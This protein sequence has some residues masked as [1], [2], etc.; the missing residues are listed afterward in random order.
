MASIVV[1]MKSPGEWAS[2][3]GVIATFA[4]GTLASHATAA[5]AQSPAAAPAPDSIARLGR[6]LFFDPA[7]SASGKLACAT[8]HDPKYAYGPPP[9][10]AIALGG[11]DMNQP[12]TRAV[13]SLRYLQGN[14]QF[15]EDLHFADGDVGPGGGLTWD[16]RAASLH[17]QAAI[18]LLAANEM[19]NAG[20]ADVVRKLARA[21]YAPLFRS[22][23]GERIFADPEAAFAAA[24][25]ALEA[26]QQVDG[27]FFPYTSRYDAFLR[28]EIELT[29]QEERGVAL[30]KDPR[31]G[32]CASCHLGVTRG[33]TPPPFTDFDFVNVGAPRNP[34]IAANSDPGYYDLGLCGPARPD[35]R[36]KQKYCGLFRSPTVRNVAI[37]DAFFHNGVF[38]SL[39]E[40][41]NFYNERDLHPEKFYPRDPDGRVHKFN[42]LPPG[43]PDNV[44]H[45]PPL[46]RK[47]GDP[48]ALTESDIDDLIAFLN[49]LTDG[50]EPPAARTTTTLDWSKPWI[51]PQDGAAAHGHSDE[52]AW[53]LFVA[54]NWPADPVRGVP[55]ATARFGSDQPVAWEAWQSAGNVYLETGADP[56]PW[57]PGVRSDP[58]DRRFETISLQD[59]PNA[60]HIVGGVMVPLVDT[61]AAAKRLT[62]IRM[63]RPTFEFIRAHELYNQE[64]QSRAH[65][66]TASLSFPLGAREVKAKW[67]P[68]AASERSRYHTI[69]VKLADGTTRLYG[70]TGLHIVSK[71]LPTWFWATFEHVDNPTLPDHEGWMLPSRD[72]FA[73]QSGPADCNGIPRGVG[74]EGTVWQYY[75]LRGTLSELQP[76]Q[77]PQLLANS[78]LEAGFQ[79][80]SS[81]NSCHSHAAVDF[82]WSLS[83]ARP[84]RQVRSSP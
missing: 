80:A 16:G 23:F 63:N 25:Q 75:R 73:C 37:R 81:C 36:D 10:K 66:Q 26:F 48:P 11:P 9:G 5:A 54:L 29:E 39:R 67:R 50:Y 56:G 7:L 84:L 74:L 42:D 55:D 83:K 47:P 49:T 72:R 15:Q 60:R 22:I 77:Q 12:G 58:P 27:E 65:E 35:L 76:G 2:V 62:E 61:V 38:A 57:L 53:R 82:V 8:C 17:E 14:P 45:D 31:K 33:S 40:V 30:F 71:D 69:S 52:Y 46:D 20:P 68:I 78:E 32:N 59:L 1:R 64:G 79:T 41:L 19:A 24:L 21:G 4:L 28:G 44:D 6:L 70:L 13:P 34:R 43:M 18:P 51:E 3:L